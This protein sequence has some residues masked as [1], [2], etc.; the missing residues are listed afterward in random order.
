MTRDSDFYHRKIRLE[1]IY[2][3][4][5]SDT[6]KYFRLKKSIFHIN[7]YT[8]RQNFYKLVPLNIWEKEDLV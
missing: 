8:L 4:K 7:D 6:Q 5:K 3:R 2:I 1:A